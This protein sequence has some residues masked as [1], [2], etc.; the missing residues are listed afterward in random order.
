MTKSILDSSKWI[1]DESLIKTLEKI[2][3]AP[4]RKYHNMEHLEKIWKYFNEDCLVGEYHDEV[5]ITTM[6]HDV[7]YIPGSKTNELESANYFWNIVGETNN[8]K[9][10]D[11]F[12]TIVATKNHIDENNQHLP[13]WSKLF[14]DLD[15]YELG[16]DWEI[17]KENGDKIFKEFSYVFTEEEIL[18]GRLS[19]Y[20]KWFNSDRIYWV[21]IEREAKAKE[22][23]LRGINE[24]ETSLDY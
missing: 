5:A 9:I 8:P 21:L 23:L 11:I 2:H 7:V 20:Q 22:N 18:K 24:I 12:D 16:S 15:V 4:Y 3:S 14:L 10:K 6:M 1:F 13:R 19:F 17:F